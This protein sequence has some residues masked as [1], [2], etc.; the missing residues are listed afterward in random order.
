VRTFSVGIDYGTSASK[1]VFW[2]DLSP[3]KP[4][5]FV[6][7]STGGTRISSSV[8][9]LDGKLHFGSFPHEA[10]LE[11]AVWYESVKMR[12]AAEANPRY[13]EF[14]YGHLPPRPQ[15]FSYE[16]LATLTVWF[17]RSHAAVAISAKLGL[18]GGDIAVSAVIGVPRRFY[19]ELA[20]RHLF[21]RV[22]HRAFL[23]HR[24]GPFPGQSLTLSA[25]REA[26]ASLPPFDSTD[27]EQRD[28]IRSEAEA[29]M[30]WPVK[31]PE[32]AAGAYAE[33]D[34]GAGTTN[35]TIVG[36]WSMRDVNGRWTKQN[37]GFHGAFSVPVAMDAIDFAIAKHV[38]L[39]AKDCLSLRGREKEMLTRSKPE[40]LK[41]V[42]DQIA[43]AYRS[44]WRRARPRF[45][46]PERE[47][48]PHHELF[49]TGGGSLLSSL[50]E[51]LAECL[52]DGPKPRKVKTLEV[53][54]DL[55]HVDG[56]PVRA[57]DVPFVSAA[58]GLSFN[59]VDA[60]E[61]FTCEI[62]KVTLPKAKSMSVIYEK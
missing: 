17:L 25:A 22:A 28:W 35:A 51:Y 32:V 52:D 55:Y 8:A 42:Y 9:L 39:Q 53:P 1:I 48:F 21:L 57:A 59:Q 50:R 34:I 36:I 27:L 43:E 24:R 19:E 7:G 16:D 23:L 38:G 31:S 2:D 4:K 12:M 11:G 61:E 6:L 3:G 33:V 10:A 60:P 20:V 49:V 41:Q 44:A 37:L 58:Y 30:F 40:V 14:C 45:T 15:E 54:T 5:A 29:A 47:S 46:P 26:L 13:G 18:P 56:T 62:E